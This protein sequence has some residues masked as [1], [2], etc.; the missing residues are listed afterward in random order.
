MSEPARRKRPVNTH[1]PISENSWQRLPFLIQYQSLNISHSY[2]SGLFC[3][4]VSFLSFSFFL[5][6]VKRHQSKAEGYSTAEA[7][8]LAPGLHHS[9]FHTCHPAG[10]LHPGG[11]A[12]LW[13]L[14]EP[15]SRARAGVRLLHSGWAELHIRGMKDTTLHV[16]SLFVFFKLLPHSRLSAFLSCR[17]SLYI[18]INTAE[19]LKQ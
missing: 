12:G 13:R 6:A 17:L 4:S 19:L 8:G 11:P 1:N 16:F 14:W 15:S 9:P 3:L 10:F 2:W 18:V 5:L 7:G